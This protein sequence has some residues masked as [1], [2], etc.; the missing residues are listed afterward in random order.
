MDPIQLKFNDDGT[1]PNSKYPLLIYNG[2]FMEEK[3]DAD[4]IISHFERYNWSNSWKNGVFDYHHYHSISHEVLA[5]YKG[6][7]TLQFG[8]EE[9][10]EVSVDEGDVVVIPAGVGH[11]RI[12]ASEDF[13]VV[14]AYPNGS[15]YDVLKGE[16]GDRPKA[17]ENIN[18]VPIPDND[19]IYG[20]MEGLLAIWKETTPES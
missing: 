16:D 3:V 8:G 10:Q 11:K 2:A 14:G 5:V 13:A 19:P 1:I 18:K 9:G 20:K 6:Y 7:A 17:D 15:E 4:Y 12:S